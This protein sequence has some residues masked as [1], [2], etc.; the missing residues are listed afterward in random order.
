[1][2]RL[3][4]LVSVVAVAALACFMSASAQA[5]PGQVFYSSGFESDAVGALPPLWGDLANS[6]D[7]FVTDEWAATGEHSFVSVTPEGET[8][9]HPVINLADIGAWPAPVSLGLEG[10]LRIESTAGSSASMG[11][12]FADP[13]DGTT[14]VTA[15]AVIFQPDGKIIWSGDGNVQIGTWPADTMTVVT[16]KVAMNTSTNIA[17]VWVDGVLFG[18]NLAALPMVIPA[19][20]VY[21]AEVNLDKF[22]FS[23]A[24]PLAD[25]TGRVFIDDVSISEFVIPVRVRITPRTLNLKSKGKFI[26]CRIDFPKGFSARAVNLSTVNLVSDDSE[27]VAGLPKPVSVHKVGRSGVTELMLKFPRADVEAIL[28]P[29]PWVELTISGTLNDGTPFSGDD[30]IRVIKPGKVHTKKDNGHGKKK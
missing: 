13:R 26:T 1:M 24:E 12:Y 7:D 23:L 10:T 28:S 18:D 20:S 14:I 11:F 4:A 17:H 21:G 25:D 5:A 3:S 30:A 15:N 2:G 6:T 22:G 29:A 16:V 27:P 9:R 8:V 19:T